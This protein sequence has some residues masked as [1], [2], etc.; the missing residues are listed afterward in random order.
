MPACHT[1][2]GIALSCIVDTS[3][4][5]PQF[6]EELSQLSLLAL[7]RVFGLTMPFWCLISKIIVMLHDQV[8]HEYLRCPKNCY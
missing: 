8:S 2:F 5:T 1:Y 4:S 7:Y 3:F 6:R